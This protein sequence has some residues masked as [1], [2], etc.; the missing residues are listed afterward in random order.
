MVHVAAAQSEEQ[1]LDATDSA[2]S[3]ASR[4]STRCHSVLNPQYPSSYWILGFSRDVRRGEVVPI[5]AF[6]R[7]LVLWRDDEGHIQ[8]FDA[9]CPHLGAN[10]GYGGEVVEGTLR[11][12]FHGWRYDNSGHVVARP[13]TVGRP[14]TKACL[15]TYRVFERYG[16]IFVW[17]GADPPDHV[18][19]DILANESINETDVVAEHMRFRLPFPGKLFSENIPDA[20]HFAALHKTGDWGEAQVVDESDTDITFELQFHGKTRWTWET[21]RQSYRRAEWD[22]SQVLSHQF[23]T[24]H[25]GGLHHFRFVSPLSD[26]ASSPATT[27]LRRRLAGGA[28]RI[29]P[30][31]LPQLLV[32]MLPV[33]AESHNLMFV[34]FVPKV[35][36]RLV[37]SVLQWLIR[38]VLEN[39][40]WVAA[41]QDTSVMLHRK[42]RQNPAYA[43]TDRALVAFRRF[44]DKRL[45]DRTLWTG[46]NIHSSGRRA[47]IIWPDAPT[48]NE[49]AITD[50]AAAAGS[51]VT[52]P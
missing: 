22:L 26:A 44:C 49:A 20:M 13:G 50:P 19:P 33:T 36:V 12:P 29:A 34:V 40:N 1:D 23:A 16:A 38:L 15:A 3:L 11:C 5:T 45:L 43:S 25:G 27:V 46:D 48:T 39:R 18:F 32:S 8:C 52:R 47:G 4:Q 7:E 35:R 6:E 30:Y 14:R 24:T 51:S 42:E 2:C 17:N 28:Q 41:V 9:I 10:V 31:L 21:I 37:G